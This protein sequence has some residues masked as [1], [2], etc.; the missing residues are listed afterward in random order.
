MFKQLFSLNSK[1][2]VVTGGTG[3]LGAEISKGLALSGAK[4]YALGR[5]K[6]PIDELNNFNKELQGEGSIEAISLDVFNPQLFENFITDIVEKNGKIDG[7]VNNAISA[8]RE[9]L[10]ELDK[11]LLFKGIHGTFTHYY[12]NSVIVAD[13][14]KKSGGG[15]IVNNG[16]LFGFLVP[17]PSMHLDLNNKASLHTAVSK[18]G[19]IQMT[20]YMAVEYAKF[21]IRVNCFSPGWF[22]KKKGP[23]R[24]DYMEQLKS[25][26][27]MNRVGKPHEIA[28]VVIFLTSQASSYVNG[29]NLIV[30]GGYTLW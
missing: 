2:F 24:P 26:I 17:K 19:V 25:H 13:K 14:M 4:V 10:D 30:D 8:K 16:S 23:E 29:Q 7:L 12:E 9:P 28:G 18:A 1:T 27:P 22:P 3:Y 15:V 11:E 5:K 6:D 20:K 21:D